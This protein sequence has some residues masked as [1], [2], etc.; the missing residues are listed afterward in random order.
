MSMARARVSAERI[1]A[2]P[3]ADVYTLLADYREGHPSILPPAF[4]EFA[5][6]EG[7][8]GAGTRIRFRLTL[9]GR[10]RDSEGVV[11]EP[12]PGRV[13][14]ESYRDQGAVTTF[15]LDPV[16]RDRTRLEIAAAWQPQGGLAGWFERLIASR[17]L[18]R[19]LEQ[20]LELIE[21]WATTRTGQ[22]APHV[23]RSSPSVSA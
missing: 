4:S 10:T 12:E 15:A 18:S 9:G 21:Q 19:L 2:A 1:I 16:D 7:G 20:E 22:S 11:E 6:L 14:T 5:V 13:L 3:A 8:V 23:P 17:P